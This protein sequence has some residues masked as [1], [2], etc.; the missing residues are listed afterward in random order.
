MNLD[1]GGSG[2]TKPKQQALF[3][4]LDVS[5]KPVK[6]RSIEATMDDDAR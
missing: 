5:I 3:L 2:H 1:V 4:H 6:T